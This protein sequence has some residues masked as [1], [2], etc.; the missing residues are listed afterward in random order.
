L[1]SNKGN[2]RSGN[3]PYRRRLTRDQR[4][5]WLRLIRSENV[6]PATFRVLINQFGC[7]EAAL[8]ALPELYRR[9]GRAQSVALT[10]RRDAEAELAAA[11]RFGAELVA[12]G[13]SGYPPAL[14]KIDAPPPL[15]YVKGRLELAER[16][17]VSVVGAR[18]G[19]AIGQKFTRLLVSELG[20]EGF[21]VASGLARGIDT[22]AHAA[23]LERGTLAVLA[24]GIDSV[25][26]P[27]NAALHAAIGAE[28]LLISERPPGF[29]PRGKDFPRRN[30]L[31]SGVAMAVVVVEAAKRSGSLITARFAGEQGRDVFAVPGNPLDPRA[32]GTNALIRQGATLIT[33][34]ADVIEAL[35]PVVKRSRKGADELDAADEHAVPAP[36]PEI[37]QSDRERLIEALGPSPVD[38]DELVRATGL[39]ARTVHIV[40]LELDLA[41][42]LQRHGRQLVSLVESVESEA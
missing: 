18:S 17:I 27:E 24:G 41:G 40:L 7:A 8:D 33:S 30:R 14:A 20:M 1:A 12:A 42:R 2:D 26:P 23:S 3:R 16:P 15:L 5:D 29:T 34:G 35:A 25:Y 10:S 32:E 31:I 19:S 9:G 21:V 38:I 11:E 4:I 39:G 22:A 37:A 6:G 28:G 36:L 13:E